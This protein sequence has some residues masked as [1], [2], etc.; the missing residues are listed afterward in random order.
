MLL[1]WLHVPAV[2]FRCTVLQVLLKEDKDNF[3]QLSKA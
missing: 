2:H 3:L 1:G